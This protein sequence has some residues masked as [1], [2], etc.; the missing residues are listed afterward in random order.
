MSSI[1]ISYSST[2]A[3]TATRLR[4]LLIARGYPTVFRDKDPDAGIPGGTKW[5]DELFANLGL[6]DIVVFLGSDASLASPWC[7]TELAVAVAQRKFI[8]QISLTDVPTH[9]LL[10]D[11]QRIPPDASLEDLVDKLVAALTRA[12]LAPRDPFTWD[13]DR[14][15]Y[16][17]LQRLDEDHAAVLFGRDQ[18]VSACVQRL[19]G[20]GRPPLLVTGPSGSGKSSLVRAGVIPRIRLQS[21]TIV[22]PIV[23]PGNAPVQRVALAL[24]E[25]IAATPT[26]GTDG[27]ATADRLIAEP[28]GFAFA[29]DRLLARG[30]GRVVLFLDQ[31]EDLVERAAPGDVADL[32][33]RL[34]AVD[35][36][37]LV[38]IAAVRSVSLDDWLREPAL[39][40]ISR[41]DPVWVRPMDR[42]ALREVVTGPAHVAGIRF[43]PPALVERIVDDTSGGNAL[44]LL[45]ALLEE[46][47]AGHSRLAPAVV[48]T[49][50]YEAVGPVS[51]VIERRAATATTEITARRG[52]PESAVVDA[53][54][55]LT[56]VDDQGRVTA[57]EVALDDVPPEARE[58][59]SDLEPHRLVARD[60]RIVAG[61]RLDGP[62]GASAAASAGRAV[63]VVS[64]VHEAVF[65]AWPAVA[66][67]IKER[68]T[69]LETRT[70][71]GRDARTWAE[72]GGGQTPLTGGRLNIARDWADRHPA[73][74]TRE[75]AAYLK[76]AIGQ[77]R[78][79][80][81]LTIAVPILLVVALVVGGLA[82]QAVTEAGRANAARAEADALRFVGE[83]RLAFETRPDL[84]Y[85]LAMEA[86]ARSD[87]LQIRA[88]PL[89][90]LVRGPGPRHY[91]AVGTPI[92]KGRLDRAGT[93]AILVT[94]A[95]LLLWDVAAGETVAT[96]PRTGEVVAISGDGSTVAFDDHGRIVVAAW[97]SGELMRT[98]DITANP[99]GITNLGLSGNGAVVA[100]AWDDAA[101]QPESL[102]AVV[103]PAG[104][105]RVPLKGI[106]SHVLAL[107]LSP[108]GDRI[109]VAVADSE[110][111]RLVWDTS[112]GEQWPDA[113]SEQLSAV[114]FGVNGGLAGLTSNGELMFWD[115]NDFSQPSQSFRLSDGRISGAAVA[116]SPTDE[117]LAAVSSDGQLRTVGT[118]QEVPIGPALKALP[119]L[120]YEGVVTPLDVATDGSRAVTIDPSGR[121]IEWDLDGRTPLGPRVEQAGFAS[122]IAPFADGSVLTASTNGVVLLA[123]DGRASFNYPSETVTAIG[124]S[125]NRWAFALGS[126]ELFATPEGGGQPQQVAKLQ[127]MWVTALAPLPGGRWA[128]TT[129]GSAGTTGAVILGP[130]A[131]TVAI[132]T[133]ATLTSI[134]AEG[135]WIFIGDMLGSVHIFDAD[136]PARPE[137]TIKPH[138]A[139]IA[140]MAVG[141]D[142]STLATGSDDRTI[143]LLTIA[144]DGS[145]T[146]RT[147]LR[148][149]EEKVTSVSFTS[150][151]RWLVS[152]S[153]DSLVRLFNVDRGIQVGDPVPTGP[154]ATVVF[155]K[156]GDR[157]AYV[158]SSGL[159]LWD[160]R[161]ESWSRIACGIIGSRRLDPVE[162][163]RFLRGVAPT[164]VCQ[165]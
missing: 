70:W 28:K 82:I 165:G 95:G 92:E 65:R 69:D 104:C 42:V 99:V 32:L 110:D 96:L 94:A 63:D 23:E 129:E 114:R 140:S 100:V 115:A 90:G 98:C 6:A 137:R 14:S 93:R 85:L 26:S 36:E 50:D 132:P 164:P 138:K 3:A 144:A 149:N 119:S 67:A 78:R 161:M 79:R 54:L 38:I 89:I 146:E 40:L 31:A 15:P 12:G 19:S 75:M 11:R 59:L 108:S 126:G 86:A 53:Y 84:G 18:E 162:E 156:N 60:Q 80:R 16:P 17:G 158:A 25:A 83:A 34:E 8:A 143:A 136:D 56:E 22:L 77:V 10:G 111:V 72:S 117:V 81:V 127:D 154:S 41:T 74:R 61:G 21:G 131:E 68:R 64:A 147:R 109:A 46:L 120:D 62:R 118:N 122:G 71:L 128:A 9:R 142:H 44:P 133:T 7:H 125:G 121:I 30:G 24:S 155:A 145:L 157:Q 97:P 101:N 47:T 45:A 5:A 33:G 20:P 163:Q 130:S 102:V 29:V 151:G 106:T 135:R 35:P 51:R 139:E 4:D 39:G 148:G 87:D 160:L 153:E 37:R 159:E 27:L 91:E 55:R 66:M 52:V 124:A 123:P 2:D 48:T 88:A 57:A 105:H 43:E 107:D 58:I 116:L 103:D 113:P 152:A 134:A 112:S 1:F 73:E 150:D 13:P 141:P 76:A 49:K